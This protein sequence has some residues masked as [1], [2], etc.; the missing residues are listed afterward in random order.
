M[1]GNPGNVELPTGGVGVFGGTFNP[2]HRGH[3]RAAEEVM[4][5]LRLDRVIFIPNARPPHKRTHQA[6]QLAPAI[7]R[8]HWTRLAVAEN[9]RFEVDPIEVERHGPSFAV[10]TLRTIGERIAPQRPVFIIGRDAF[11]EI[12]SWREP[13][14]LFELSN[15]AVMT[16]PP[17]DG[18]T[19]ADWLPAALQ[20]EFE[21]SADGQVA[22]HRYADTWI[23]GLRITPIDV[24]AS[25]I[26]S[27]LRRGESVAECVPPDVC[28]AIMESG[29]YQASPE[30]QTEPSDRAEGAAPADEQLER[31]R[32]ALRAAS[33]L[34]AEDP[35]A[36]DVREVTAFADTFLILSGQSDRQV[37]SIADAI[38]Q[39]MSMSGEKPLGVEGY[40]EGRWVLLDFTDLIVH[41]FGPGAREQYDLE[42][43]WSDAPRIDISADELRASA[44]E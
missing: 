29:I 3:L 7:D 10:D 34:K 28:R 37:R 2:I 31:T 24:S 20:D 17:I 30:R 42:R 36:L 32:R 21:M 14:V 11:S 19:L 12:A 33:E 8:L 39:A 38:A 41:V 44:G 22:R 15:F 27:R 4:E 5:R 26:R 40:D 35:T 23:R 16:R 25:E 13:R 1:T 9:L 43:L 18:G 6:L